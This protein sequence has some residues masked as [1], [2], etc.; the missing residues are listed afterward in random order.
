MKRITIRIVAS[1]VLC[2]LGLGYGLLMAF[3]GSALIGAGHGTTFFQYLYEAP[4]PVGKFI[5]PAVGALLPWV[6][7]RPCRLASGAL[8][9][10]NLISVCVALT[11]DGVIEGIT[12][13]IKLAPIF[14]VPV[15]SIYCGI[16]LGIVLVLMLG[17]RRRFPA[18]LSGLKKKNT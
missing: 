2:A 8:L 17:G 6:S 13:S 9:L 18:G 10:V 3:V 14:A 4:E 16:F 5:W 11:G 15:L 1:V 12:K 7:S